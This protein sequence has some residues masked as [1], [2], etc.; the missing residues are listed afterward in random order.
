MRKTELKHWTSDSEKGR[1]DLI[2]EKDWVKIEKIH[3]KKNRRTKLKHRRS[4]SKKRMTD[5]INVKDWVKTRKAKFKNATGP[6]RIYAFCTCNISEEMSPENDFT[7]VA[8]IHSVFN[9]RCSWAYMKNL[10]PVCYFICFL[11]GLF[12]KSTE[13]FSETATEGVLENN[14]LKNLPKSTGRHL[15]QSFFCD[16]VAG[17]TPA[18]LWKRD[19]DT[20]VFIWILQNFWEHF[21]YRAPIGDSLLVFL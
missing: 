2:N 15:C 5:S 19:S 10:F 6:T 4:N 1:D 12:R 3:L 13:W 18:T 8:T 7:R 14:V 21:F 9:E 11:I 16:K 17:L 20:D